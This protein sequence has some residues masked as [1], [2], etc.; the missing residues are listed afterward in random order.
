MREGVQSVVAISPFD[1][2]YGKKSRSGGRFAL[3]HRGAKTVKPDE[4]FSLWDSLMIGINNGIE[5]K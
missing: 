2:I 1:F 5:I 3:P 4:D